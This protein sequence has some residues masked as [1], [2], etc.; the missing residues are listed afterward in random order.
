MRFVLPLLALLIASPALGQS[1]PFYPVQGV[2]TDADDVPI[3]GDVE[4]S[5]ALYEAETGGTAQ[6]SES[7]T[8]AFTDGLFTAY[9]GE[10]NDLSASLFAGHDGLWLGISIGTN[11]E[12]PRVFVG[13]SPYAGYAELAGSVGVDALPTEA[14]L[15]DQACAGNAVA[16]GLSAT[17]ELLCDA[18][19]S[20]DQQC[21][22]G[23]YVAGL[24]VDGALICLPDE[25]QLYDGSNFA[26]S[27]TQC[28]SGYVMVGV[29]PSGQPDCQPDADSVYSGA[30]FATSDQLCTEGDFVAGINPD[31]TVLCEPG[32]DVTSVHGL[33]GGTI[34]GDT[35]V[36]G[37]LGVSGDLT[38]SG[39]LTVAG[40]L[41][42]GG[43]NLG[44]LDD[45]LVLMG[46][47][48]SFCTASSGTNVGWVKYPR[49][50][51]AEPVF[52]AGM[53]ESLSASG[54]SWI[55][56]EQSW[57][58][59]A[60]VRCNSNLDAL[61]WMAIDAGRH[62]IDGKN[63]EAG[64][65][66]GAPTLASGSAVFF[67]QAF[68]APPVVI[69][70]IDE[71]GNQNG[72]TRLR[73]INQVGVS[74]FEVWLDSSVD[75]LSYIAMDPGEYFYGRYHI[76]AGVWNVNNACSPNSNNC[77]QSLP[78]GMFGQAVNGL[79]MVHD[80]NNSGPR[81][82]RARRLEPESV[83]LQLESNTEF[84]HYVVWEEL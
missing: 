64:V 68:Q 47:E 9:L 11:G 45:P 40:T 23:D 21:Q 50:F 59:R 39:S 49:A 71:T 54:A 33:T 38:V 20:W 25:G 44:F 73:L 3:D 35:D 76:Y 34:T 51:D 31:G 80:T 41:N 22:S 5:F 7:Q 19:A 27:G 53:D 62:V 13:S 75:A 15:G 43:E 14:V 12:M 26:L 37:D 72:G 58:N 4:L 69:A 74:G 65:F 52:V 77:T 60:G 63:V 78:G 79:F 56:T 29:T 48:P 10:V 55:R 83:T 61:H 16:I 70:Q 8:I 57:R 6:W 24:D 36:I 66:Q 2:L 17:G 46:M 81:Y 1:N 28:I 18:P 82:V 84:V 30:D 42:V 67:S 32:D